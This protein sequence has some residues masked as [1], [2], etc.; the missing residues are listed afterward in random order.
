ME[1][2]LDHVIFYI[3]QT[4][5]SW[6]FP[7]PFIQYFDFYFLFSRNCDTSN[8]G[9]Y[10]LILYTWVCCFYVQKKK[11]VKRLKSSLEPAAIEMSEL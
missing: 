9:I 1:F 6:S 3:R 4:I 10:F 2:P 5:F 11:F 8:L 7:F